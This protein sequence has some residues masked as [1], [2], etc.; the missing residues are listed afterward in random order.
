ME[1]ELRKRNRDRKR[2]TTQKGNDFSLPSFHGKLEVIYRSLKLMF[3]DP[4]THV[5]VSAS[6]KVGKNAFLK[7]NLG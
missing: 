3:R 7:Q 4:I 5:T 6:V 2:C 1:K